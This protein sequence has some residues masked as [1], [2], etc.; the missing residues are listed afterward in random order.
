MPDYHPGGKTVT[1]LALV[2]SHGHLENGIAAFIFVHL[3]QLEVCEI[4]VLFYASME[5]V[6]RN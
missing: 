2:R 4:F 1:D 6:W 5:R 3:T